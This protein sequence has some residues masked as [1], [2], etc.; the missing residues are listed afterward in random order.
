VRVHLPRH[1]RVCGLAALIEAEQTCCQFLTFGLS[2]GIDAI[3]M[4]VTGPDGAEEIV[5]A[6]VGAAC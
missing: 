6:L 5:H 2:V 4:D 1:T 3:T